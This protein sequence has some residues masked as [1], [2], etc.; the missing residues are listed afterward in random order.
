MSWAVLLLRLPDD[1]TS[2]QDI[3]DD[4]TPPSLCRQKEVL[5]AVSQAAPK[6]D[7]SDPTWGELCGP[8]W[9]IELNIG[10]DDPVDSI[11]LHIRGTGDDV[12]TPV[13]RLADALECKVLDCS[14]GD[15]IT[16][17]ELSG[18]HLIQEFRDRVIY[19]S[20]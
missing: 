17:Q 12:L 3:P 15:L 8:T 2:L 11:M 4:Y 19:P 13:F 5:A 6:A 16:P 14:T 10:D 18:W 7:L 9:S 1:F 20:H